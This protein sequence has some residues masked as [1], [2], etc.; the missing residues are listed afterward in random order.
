MNLG[1]VECEEIANRL[2]RHA[3]ALAHAHSLIQGLCDV[4][5]DVIRAEM[6]SLDAMDDH[7]ESLCVAMRSIAMRLDRGA[8]GKFDPERREA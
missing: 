8:L 5:P 7:A 1:P 6:Q 2:M 3:S 4:A